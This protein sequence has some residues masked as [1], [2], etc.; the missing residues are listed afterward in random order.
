MSREDS[1]DEIK[2]ISKVNRVL[3]AVLCALLVLAAAVVAWSFLPRTAEDWNDRGE[4]LAKKEKYEKSLE[5]FDRALEL[6][7]V[8]P[9]YLG[10]RGNA[11]LYLGDFKKAVEDFSLVIEIDPSDGAAYYN[12]GVAYSRLELY[13]DA[14]IDLNRA[15]ELG[16][17]KGCDGAERIMEAF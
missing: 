9:V 6:E 14:L 7:P 3:F 8:S 5:C 12:R 17:E 2:T 1:T 11:R 15:C 13:A 10:N 16:I 4:K